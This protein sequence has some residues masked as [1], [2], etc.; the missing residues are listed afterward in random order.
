[1]PQPQ[2]LQEMNERLPVFS[3]ITSLMREALM[4]NRSDSASA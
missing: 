1:M 2:I 3:L 4:P